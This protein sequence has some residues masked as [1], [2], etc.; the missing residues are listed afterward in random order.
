MAMSVSKQIAFFAIS[1][2]HTASVFG[3][4]CS[5]L[6]CVFRYVRQ[7]SG[8]CAVVSD[9]HTINFK[10]VQ[11]F[12]QFFNIIK[13]TGGFNDNGSAVFLY[14]ENFIINKIVC[15]ISKKLYCAAIINIQFTLI[16]RNGF[17]CVF[18]HH[19]NLRAFDF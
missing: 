6:R 15:F 13:E 17:K 10:A 7:E 16:E 19:D 14:N 12:R 4:V 3:V 11:V 9:K 18:I 2:G 5:I 1:L 8:A